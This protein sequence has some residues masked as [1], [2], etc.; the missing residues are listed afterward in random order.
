MRYLF[1]VM[2]MLLGSANPSSAQVSVSIGFNLPVYPELVRVPGYPVYYAPR[3]QTNFFFYDGFYW[4]F[5]DDRW[6]ASAWYNGPWGQVVPEAVPL[7]VLRIP[8]RYF[9]QPPGYF[10]GWRADAPPRWNE[11]WGPAWARQRS[12][13]DQW[14]PRSVP[15]P[16]PLPIYQRKY[17]GERY[18]TEAQQQT[19]HERNYRYQPREAVVPQVRREDDKPGAS[20]PAPPRAQRADRDVSP[21]P[22]Q[23]DRQR[24]LATVQP[25]QAGERG[26]RAQ[27]GGER[28]SPPA[29]VL[30]QDSSKDRGNPQDAGRVHWQEKEKEK[31]RERDTGEER[32]QGRN[33]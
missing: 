23:L 8:V 14:N 17:A 30:R 29:P 2:A 26:P 16:A 13:W 7:F 32:G 28:S 21:G 12:G 1:L 20:M 11:Y 5:Q 15:A 6:Y 18:P 33:R 3:L 19:L 25:P 27:P 31:G 9:R 4:V 10:R 24:P 22:Q